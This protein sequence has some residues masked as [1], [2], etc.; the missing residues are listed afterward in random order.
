MSPTSASV[1]FSIKDKA[2]GVC[3]RPHETGQIGEQIEMLTSREG[4][5][6]WV[7]EPCS[8]E[9]SH[10][11][12]RRGNC[13][14]MPEAKVDLNSAWL[15]GNPWLRPILSPI[16]IHT[17]TGCQGNHLK[18]AFHLKKVPMSTFQQYKSQNWDSEHS[19]FRLVPM[20][21]GLAENG[22][23]LSRFGHLGLDS[24]NPCH[25]THVKSDLLRSNHLWPAS[26]SVMAMIDRS[27]NSDWHTGQ[28][29]LFTSWSK[30]HQWNICNW[31]TSPIHRE[32]LTN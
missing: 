26:A 25:S 20:R 10:L 30:N 8:Q 15:S 22:Q 24:C 9:H 31:E 17:Q 18:A 12:A 16:V 14:A 6:D 1:T 27:S 3:I 2:N 32:N 13:I 28:T 21:Q 7:H 5:K 29:N 4:K 11:A 23:R 19:H